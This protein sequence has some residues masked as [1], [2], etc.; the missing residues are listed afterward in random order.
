MALPT[1]DDQHK[2]QLITIVGSIH[3]LTL[4][5]V[6][7]TQV[8]RRPIIKFEFTPTTNSKF[9]IVNKQFVHVILDLPLLYA[10]LNIHII[11]IY[12]K[13]TSIGLNP[14]SRGD[15]PLRIRQ[16]GSESSESSHQQILILHFQQFNIRVLIGNCACLP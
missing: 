8:I 11:Y 3:Y 6:Q 4:K 10:I 15:Y 2:L 16:I 14:V 5:L 12:C 9:L 7:S 1:P 13:I